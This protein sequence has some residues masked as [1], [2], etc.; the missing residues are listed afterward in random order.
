MKFSPTEGVAVI[1]AGYA[2]MA[3]AM[4]LVD[5][6][7]PVTVFEAG[8]VPGGRARR[9]PGGDGQDDN[10]QHLLLGAYTELLG[11][12]QRLQIPVQDVLYRRGLMLHI[13][14]G[15]RLNALPLPSPWHLAGG[16]LLARGASW[17]ERIDTL[18]ALQR[19]QDT[20]FR[21]EA[22]ETVA[23]LLDRLGL[24]GA[25]RTHLWESICLA[26]LNTP[27]TRAC[28]QVFLN[29]LHDIATGPRSH[30]DLLMPRTDLSSLFPE[31][32]AAYVRARGGQVLLQTPVLRVEDAGPLV[33]VVT[34]HQHRLFQRAILAV[35][36]RA[37]ARMIGDWPEMQPLL[38]QLAALPHERI[39]TLTLEYD[40]P[41][42]LPHPMMGLANSCVEWM[43]DRRWLLGGGL[44]A[45]GRIAC[46]LSAPSAGAVLDRE[47]L[48]SQAH[49]DLERLV[50]RLPYPVS[51]RLVVEKF[52]TFSCQPRLSRPDGITHDPR[53]LL[54]GDYL[55]SRYPATLESAVRSGRRAAAAA[56]QWSGRGM[57]SRFVRATPASAAVPAS[58]T[59]LPPG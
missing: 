24:E 29:I 43:F 31:P 45:P 27:P 17:G 15:L 48:I 42:R 16:I 52:A 44:R 2:G 56:V 37:L 4:D 5:A 33:R 23:A 36:P 12:L 40:R 59:L 32:A 57:P 50:G 11:L 9:I 3:A 38:T 25:L 19:L 51:G 6:G 53:I 1:G 35:Q 34:G 7:V 46:V 54:A 14:G 39:A 21:A 49:A 47:M 20:G 55:V 28:A 26:A 22:G 13:A 58:P 8:P 10:G 41:V 18:H 30:S